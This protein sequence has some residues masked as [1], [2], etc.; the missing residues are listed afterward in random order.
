MY[1][2]RSSADDSSDAQD[3]E[4][5]LSSDGEEE[6]SEDGD[7]YEAEPRGLD[8]DTFGM[9]VCALTRDT[10][11][12]AKHGLGCNRFVRIFATLLLAFFTL[13]MQIFLLQKVKQ[14]VSA[15]AVHDIRIAYS[16]FQN[17]QGVP[18]AEH[19]MRDEQCA[20]PR[21]AHDSS[22]NRTHNTF[23]PCGPM[24]MGV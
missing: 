22:P 2:A 12:I 14:F 3:V 13:G 20:G 11:F 6:E 4:S 8:D 16:E 17:V 7:V 1:L 10:H 23:S 18:R 9:S 24:Q 21:V 15:K 19:P 5:M